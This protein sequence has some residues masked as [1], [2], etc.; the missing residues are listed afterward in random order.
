MFRRD[1]LPDHFEDVELLAPFRPDTAVESV[2]LVRKCNN[3]LGLLV[4]LRAGLNRLLQRNKLHLDTPPLN[5]T[6]SKALFLL[7]EAFSKVSALDTQWLDQDD[8]LHAS[9][10]MALKFLTLSAF[11]QKRMGFHPLLPPVEK[12]YVRFYQVWVDEVLAYQDSLQRPEGTFEDNG[13]KDIANAAKAYPREMCPKC[14]K[15]RQIYC[16][17]CGGLRMPIGGA[18]LPPRVDLPFD[19]LLLVHW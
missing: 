8:F 9:D 3:S 2:A 11:L 13:S 4:K 14:K 6:K 12:Y 15:R 10:I 5:L 19:I 1:D 7:W 17:T 18:T 16:G